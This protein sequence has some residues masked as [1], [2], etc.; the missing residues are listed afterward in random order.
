[1]NT[2]GPMPREVDKRTPFTSCSRGKS[3]PST[4][5]REHERQQERLAEV[6]G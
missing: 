3:Y 4:T 6:V 2:P 5:R 1:M